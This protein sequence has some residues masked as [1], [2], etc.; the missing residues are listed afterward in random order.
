MMGK[1]EVFLGVSKTYSDCYERLA[2]MRVGLMMFR[3]ESGGSLKT[4]EGMHGPELK[5]FPS[6]STLEDEGYSMVF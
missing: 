3:L 2:V 5:D 6:V 1:R 4:T